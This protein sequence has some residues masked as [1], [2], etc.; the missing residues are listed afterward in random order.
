MFIVMNY[1]RK[2]HLKLKLEAFKFGNVY[3]SSV[4][5]TDMSIFYEIIAFPWSLKHCY[6]REKCLNSFLYTNQHL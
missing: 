6:L 4:I 5:I 1:T 2:W 3:Y